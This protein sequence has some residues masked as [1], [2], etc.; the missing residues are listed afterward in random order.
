MRLIRLLPAVKGCNGRSIHWLAS[1]KSMTKRTLFSMPSGFF[2]YK[3]SGLERWDTQLFYSPNDFITEECFISL[4]E[5]FLSLS[6]IITAVIAFLGA[7]CILFFEVDLVVEEPIMGSRFI[8]SDIME[9]F[10]FHSSIFCTI[11]VFES[12]IRIILYWSESSLCAGL[13]TFG[14]ATFCASTFGAWGCP[15]GVSWATLVQSQW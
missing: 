1:E 8:L 5:A 15:A 12:G 11:C 13:G 2:D 10:G 3:G 14:A 7:P 6:G 9:N 4:F